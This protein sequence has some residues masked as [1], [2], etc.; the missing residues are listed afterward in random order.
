[1][2]FFNQCIVI[3]SWLKYR[4][5]GKSATSGRVSADAISGA[6]HLIMSNAF[7]KIC[8]FALN[9]VMLRYSGPAV[10]GL[11]SIELEL[12]LS[13]LLFLSRYTEIGYIYFI[14]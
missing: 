3:Y 13:T 5:M 1:M 7:Q 12:L 8:T 11:A 9:Q 4:D 2:V 6:Q 10:F 14:L